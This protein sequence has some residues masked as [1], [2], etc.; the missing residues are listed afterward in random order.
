MTKHKGGAKMADI[1]Y[2][3]GKK[4]LMAAGWL[5]PAVLARVIEIMEEDGVT[6]KM[7]VQQL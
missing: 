7:R 3:F 6:E 4:N 1:G 5:S 2:F